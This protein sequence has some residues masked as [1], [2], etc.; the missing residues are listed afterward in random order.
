MF[1]GIACAAFGAT[2]ITFI[3]LC[4]RV[5]FFCAELD[6]RQRSELFLIWQSVSV[7]AAVTHSAHPCVRQIRIY[8]EMFSQKRINKEKKSKDTAEN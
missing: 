7:Y 3:V 8:G 5:T 6:L 1:Y 4:V 2:T